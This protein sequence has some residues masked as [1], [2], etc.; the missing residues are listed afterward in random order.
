MLNKGKA[1]G[2]LSCRVSGRK[3]NN[4]VLYFGSNLNKQPFSPP[5]SSLPSGQ[6]DMKRK[7]LRVN[8][9]NSIQDRKSVV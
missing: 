4:N 5:T 6:R 1:A 3:D 7:L 2:D 9:A 8:G